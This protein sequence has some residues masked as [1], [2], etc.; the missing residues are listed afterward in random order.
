MIKLVNYIFRLN[1]KT[2]INHM[3]YIFPTLNV[4][5]NTLDEAKDF[6]CEHLKTNVRTA[7]K[8][9]KFVANNLLIALTD[10]KLDQL[11]FGNYLTISDRAASGTITFEL[12]ECSTK[13]F[14]W[15]YDNVKK[16]LKLL[17]T[18]DVNVMHHALGD[19]NA[20][21]SAETVKVVD[22]NVEAVKSVNAVKAVETAIESNDNSQLNE[23]EANGD[24]QLNKVEA[25][26]STYVCTMTKESIST[27]WCNSKGE[28]HRLDG[29]AIEFTN[30][31]KQWCQNGQLHR[32]DGPAI[33]YS[34][35]RKSWYLN[36]FCFTEKEF[37]N[38]TAADADTVATA[39]TVVTPLSEWSIA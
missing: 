32:T 1:G 8:T 14:G 9:I 11:E 4:Y 25:S 18:F 3:I 27:K 16:R 15:V 17:T 22:T 19:T 21:K 29:P 35:G 31:Q 33:E 39:D 28:L 5:V 20:D 23:V 38:R 30:G 34:N 26:A 13:Q 6:L 24:L 2:S 36:G 7:D 12:Y 37:L 10:E